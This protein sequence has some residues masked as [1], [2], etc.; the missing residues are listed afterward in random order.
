MITQKRFISIGAIILLLMALGVMHSQAQPAQRSAPS[1]RVEL[2]ELRDVPLEDALRLLS[3][4][5]G[6]NIVS[7]SGAAKTP[8]SLYLKNVD[9]LDAL[10]ALCSANNLWFRRDPN[11]GIY[12]INT[13]QEYQRDLLTFREQRTEVYT[14]LYPNAK[15]V[16]V[17]IADLFGERVQLSLGLDPQDALDE[18][19]QRFERFDLL[20]ERGQDSSRGFGSSG[21]SGLGA[22]GLGSSRLT[23]RA[24]GVGST[25]R[26][27]TTRQMLSRRAGE[28]IIEELG[29]TPEE[30]QQIE[31]ITRGEDIADPDVLTEVLRRSQ[32]TIFV[33][34][35]PKHNKVIVRTSD[36]RTASEIGALVRQ[37]DVPT[38]L[39]LLEVKVLSINLGDDLDTAFDFNFQAG[40]FT[41]GFTEGPI[42][43]PA[44]F[45]GGGFDSSR[46]IFQIVGSNFSARLQALERDNRVTTLATPLLLTA[47]N[48]VSRLFVGQTIPILTGFTQGATVVSGSGPAT[49][50][51][52][53]P[54]YELEDVGNTLL[55]TP[56]INADRSVTLRI[57]QQE[58]EVVRD[59]A[60]ILVPGRSTVTDNV[61]GISLDFASRN[62]DI[63]ARQTVSGTV[64]AQDGIPIAF[65]GLIRERV[66]D[67]R[68]FVPI[69]GEIPILDLFFSR[70]SKGRSREE[71]IVVI[72]P[73]VLTTPMDGE[74]ISRNLLRDLTLLPEAAIGDE[75]FDTYERIELPEPDPGLRRR[76]LYHST[77]DQ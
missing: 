50:I 20:D 69:L 21:R 4:Q 9:A 68:D 75:Q 38:P 72:R 1:I 64:V 24:R 16:A 70:I 10:E 12:R 15:D 30:I 46:G 56:N 22:G 43:N 48:E 19:E 32:A 62:I 13:V 27:P 6:L 55:I 29:L 26:T 39:V 3:L 31:A 71:L 74:T 25:R 77:D 76:F 18:L 8:V 54:N 61:G 73:Y 42:I 37:L 7:S 33:T 51:P 28:T 35:I 47:N 40:D 58:S 2:I 65:G 57:L 36:E 59:G 23:D 11:T 41:G 66:F 5:T 67:R 60:R 52:P 34:V 45:A 63:V 17:A 44:P 49:E 53:T 14:L